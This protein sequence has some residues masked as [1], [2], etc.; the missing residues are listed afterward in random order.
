MLHTEFYH[1]CA[2]I[3]WWHFNCRKFGVP[4]RLL[5]HSPQE[6]IR[7]KITGHHLKRIGMRPGFPDLMLYVQRGHYGGMAIEMKAE[8]GRATKEQNEFLEDLKAQGYA[9][10]I[11]RS[12]EDARNKIV[13]YLSGKPLDE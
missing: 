9:T 2:L 7:S 4:E 6:G 8:N 3:D 11:C 12:W 5:H 1:Q 13:D 10:Y